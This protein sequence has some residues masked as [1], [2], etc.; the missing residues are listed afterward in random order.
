MTLFLFVFFTRCMWAQQSFSPLIDNERK[1]F[2]SSHNASTCAISDN[3]DVKYYRCC[4]NIDPA[5]NQV[6]GNITTYF[7]PQSPLD[8]IQMD[9]SV[10]LSI[11]S[12]WHHYVKIN[13]T[14]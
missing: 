1:S 14:Q 9:A 8:S 11:D 13:F 5:I 12:I 6:V 4:W 3:Y 10:T 2:L 7:L